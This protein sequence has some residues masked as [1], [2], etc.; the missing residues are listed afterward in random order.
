MV[1]L[2]RLHHWARHFKCFKSMKQKFLTG[3]A[4][5]IVIPAKAGIQFH[6]DQCTFTHYLFYSKSESKIPF[7]FF[8]N[9]KDFFFRSQLGIVFAYNF[10]SLINR[11]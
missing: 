8:F 7:S 5:E 3:I 10:T 2:C 9:P 4:K 1:E 6:Y 11:L